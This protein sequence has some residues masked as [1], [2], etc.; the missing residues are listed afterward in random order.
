[1][2]GA[3]LERAAKLAGR[4]SGDSTVAYGW[5]YAQAVESARMG[6]GGRRR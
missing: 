2:T 3:D 5:A 1:M 6:W 4:T